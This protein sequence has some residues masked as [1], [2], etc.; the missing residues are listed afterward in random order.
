MDYSALIVTT[1]GKAYARF[2]P[3]THYNDVKGDKGVRLG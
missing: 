1:P 2:S 3:G